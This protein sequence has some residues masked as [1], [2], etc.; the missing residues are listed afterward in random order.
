MSQIQPRPIGERL[1]TSTKCGSNRLLLLCIIF[2]AL[3]LLYTANKLINNC[4]GFKYIKFITV[5]IYLLLPHKPRVSG[6]HS[7][8]NCLIYFILLRYDIIYGKIFKNHKNALL[9]K[10][11]IFLSSLKTV[12]EYSSTTKNRQK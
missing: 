5:Q 8:E 12:G 3:I 4:I 1:T 2:Y 11:F 10:N 7:S 6:S 9:A